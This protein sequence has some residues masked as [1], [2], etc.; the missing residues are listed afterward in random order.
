MGPRVI[1]ALALV[2]LA[3]CSAAPV[4][5]DPAVAELT[6]QLDLARDEIGQLERQLAKATGANEDSAARIEEME[7][8]VE[9]LGEELEAATVAAETAAAAT[10]PM[11]SAAGPSRL[12]PS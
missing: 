9:R 2:L 10:T 12:A 3:A 7:S 11:P 6:E 8:D 4:P 5:A 1:V